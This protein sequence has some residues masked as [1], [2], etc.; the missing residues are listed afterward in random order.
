MRLTSSKYEKSDQFHP[1]LGQH[2]DLVNNQQV[3]K[4]ETQFILLMI[5][6]QRWILLM[7]YISHT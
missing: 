2:I 4:I 3:T 6:Y 7:Q 5:I 1:K